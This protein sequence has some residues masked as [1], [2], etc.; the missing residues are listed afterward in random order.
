M[1]KIKETYYFKNTNGIYE[2]LCTC[3]RGL[4]NM[5]TGEVLDENYFKNTHFVDHNI[6]L[7]FILK[8]ICKTLKAIVDN[9]QAFEH[10]VW[11]Y[12][13]HV[14]HIGFDYSCPY[15]NSP[16]TKI[17]FEVITSDERYIII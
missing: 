13:N 1:I 14:K 2:E 4:M 17:M 16:D 3:E 15:H 8:D 6:N 12:G 7:E 10:D 9:K 5:C 11:I